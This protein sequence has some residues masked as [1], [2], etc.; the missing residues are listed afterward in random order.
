[1]LM[2]ERRQKRIE[3][4][5]AFLWTLKTQQRIGLRDIVTGDEN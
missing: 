4:S 1:M 3:R 2:Q 5:H